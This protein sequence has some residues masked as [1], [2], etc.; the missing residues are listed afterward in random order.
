[1]H[2]RRLV[3]AIAA[4]GAAYRLVGRP[5]ERWGASTEEARAPLPGDEVVPHPTGEATHAVTIGV[6][7]EAVWPW[8]AQ[9][10]CGRAGWYTYP[11]IEGGHPDP[12]RIHPQYQHIAEGDLVPDSP[13]GSITWTVAAAEQ[14]RLLVYTTTRRL[15]SQRNVDPDNP[16]APAWYRGSWAFILRPAGPGSTRLIVRWRHQLASAHP[17]LDPATEFA[18]LAGHAFMSRKQLHSIRQRA[19]NAARMVPGNGLPATPV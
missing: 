16:G 12:D 11:W 4:G 7:P 3:Q 1:M 5:W 2:I 14:P 18:L 10:G 6:P 17:G 9:M 8:L 13:D 15:R 19:Q